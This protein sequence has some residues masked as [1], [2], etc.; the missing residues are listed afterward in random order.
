MALHWIWWIAAA[1]AVGAELLTGTFYLLAIGAA[2]AAGGVAAWLG[3]TLEMQFLIAGA[4][5]LALT[6]VA[7]NWRVQRVMPAPQAGLDIGHEVQ[8]RQWRPDGNAR[9]FYRGTLWDAEL[10][11][12]DVIREAPLYIV[13]TKGSVLVLGNQRPAE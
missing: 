12:P 4:L 13:A 6:I 2:V 8:V 9:V 10:A 5:G 11:G 3:W 1:L 7:H